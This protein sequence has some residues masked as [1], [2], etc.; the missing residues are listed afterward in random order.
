MRTWKKM[1]GG[2]R[3]GAP[4]AATR[5]HRAAHGHS[6]VSCGQKPTL[7]PMFQLRVWK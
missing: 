2:E 5:E 3:V 1:S 7:V 6:A 4:C